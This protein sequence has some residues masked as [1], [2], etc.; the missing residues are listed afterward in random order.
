MSLPYSQDTGEQ[1]DTFQQALTYESGEHDHVC[2]LTPSQN[3]TDLKFGPRKIR[4]WFYSLLVAYNRHPAAAG[5]LRSRRKVRAEVKRQSFSRYWFM[6]HP[7][8][9]LSLCYEIAMS[10]LGLTALFVIAFLNA[11]HVELLAYWPHESIL[12]TL[13]AITVL[14]T[15]DVVY[16]LWTGYVHGLTIILNPLGVA[17]Q[18]L[19]RFLPVDGVVLAAIAYLAASASRRSDA[20]TAAMRTTSTTTS[21]SLV[22]SVLNNVTLLKLLTLPRCYKY[23]SRLAEFLQLGDIQYRIL[24]LT[25][26]SL[27]LTHISA[28]LYKKFY[29]VSNFYPHLYP[30]SLPSIGGRLY[31]YS[32]LRTSW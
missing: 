26:T 4:T 17:L 1:P 8:S 23:L 25:I 20:T 27:L 18:Y 21:I 9:R 14:C 19:K 30:H 6:I 3:F 24:R 29:H 15:L 32:I 5:Y 28:C 31:S 7:F 11:F 12:A 16:N 10:P 2:T 13:L 22:E